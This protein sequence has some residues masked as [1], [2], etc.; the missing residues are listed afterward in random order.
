[1][2]PIQKQPKCVRACVRLS[3]TKLRLFVAFHSD[4]DRCLTA[5]KIQ[6]HRKERANCPTQNMQPTRTYKTLKHEI[7]AS[8]THTTEAH[9]IPFI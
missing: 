1:M 6:L 4:Y 5:T 3:G 8:Q 2:K 7:A 9:I